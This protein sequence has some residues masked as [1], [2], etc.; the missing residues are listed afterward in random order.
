MSG[1]SS[2]LLILLLGLILLAEARDVAGQDAVPVT[3]PV[4]L[5]MIRDVAIHD[6]LQLTTAQRAEVTQ[7]LKSVDGRWFRSRIL[8]PEKQQPELAMLTSQLRGQLDAILDAKQRERLVQL[9]RQALGTRMLTRADVARALKLTP[10]KEQLLREA[11]VE[12]DQRAS[13]LQQQ[14]Q[15]G[16]LTAAEAQ[17][18][19]AKLKTAEQNQLLEKLSTAKRASLAR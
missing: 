18:Q 1:I 19:V 13:E 4:L 11:F 5:Q 9:E 7:A 14:V 6:E 3:P 2:R 16:E 8:P 10:A 15:K 12:T 17:E